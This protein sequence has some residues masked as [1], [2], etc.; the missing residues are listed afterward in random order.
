MTIEVIFLHQN[1]SYF[2]QKSGFGG[3]LKNRIC[4]PLLSRAPSS[5]YLLIKEI[6][7]AQTRVSSSTVSNTARRLVK[8]N[9]SYNFDDNE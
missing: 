4:H 1:I 8:Y 2:P 6:S 5:R 3:Y 9:Q 7:I